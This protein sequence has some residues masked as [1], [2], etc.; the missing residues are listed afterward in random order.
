MFSKYWFSSSVGS[1]PLA[2]Y[3]QSP[4]LGFVPLMIRRVFHTKV[5]FLKKEENHLFSNLSKNTRSEIRRAAKIGLVCSDSIDISCAAQFFNT[6]AASRN[7]VQFDSLKFS[8][9]KLFV[10]QVCHENTILSVHIYLVDK[11]VGCARLLHSGTIIDP[12]PHISNALIGMANRSLHWWDITRFK[13]AGLD[14]YDLGGYAINSTD[15]TLVGINRFK[16]S[17]GGSLVAYYHYYGLIAWVLIELRAA[18]KKMG[19]I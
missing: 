8:S 7:I 17:F 2:I 14:I 11:D 10:T 18:V 4:D 6:F 19:L 16:D 12:P 1:N 15:K 5:L 3:Y 9:E 13:D